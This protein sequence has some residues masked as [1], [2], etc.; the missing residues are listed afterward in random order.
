MPGFRHS[1]LDDIQRIRQDLRDRY[2]DGFPILKELLQ[3]ADDAGASEPNGV[4]EYSRHSRFCRNRSRAMFVRVSAAVSSLAVA[5]SVFAFSAKP[6]EAC[7][8]ARAGRGGSCTCQAAW[9]GI[10]RCYS[11][12]SEQCIMSGNRCPNWTP[13]DLPENP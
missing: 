3:N 9:Q 2:Q 7:Y 8:T 5:L 4:G 1:P 11:P 10:E 6:A 13:G 12:N